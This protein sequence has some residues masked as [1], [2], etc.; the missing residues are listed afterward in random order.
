MNGAVSRSARSGSILVSLKN[1]EETLAISLPTVLDA[2]IGR[3]TKEACDDRLRGWSRRLVENARIVLD[4]HG[5]ENLVRD[6]TYFV[7]SNHQSHYD[8]PVLF[9]AIG[10]NL[11]MVTKKELFRIPIFGAAL[12]AAGFV[13]V[14]RG[15]RA[16]AIASL[17]DARVHMQRGV[18]VWIAP[19][20][21]RSRTGDLLPFKRGPFTLALDIGLPVLPVS[22]Q[23]TKNVLAAD[24]ART[25]RDQRVSVT[26]HAPIDL[27]PYR[28]LGKK[29]RDPLITEV[30]RAVE[31]GL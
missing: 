2:A 8:V 16:R 13:E 27:A 10:A 22:I 5:K 19:E 21:T 7:M 31:S 11:R 17:E 4:V 25:Y 24:A 29:G 14:D 26:I 1:V 12:R 23:G 3:G 18:H 6:Q 28:A 15:D 20:G 9:C 30:R